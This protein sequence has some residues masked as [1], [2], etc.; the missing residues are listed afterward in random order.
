MVALKIDDIKQFTTML[1]MKE[2]FDWFLVKEVDIV[3]FNAF[4]IDG[5]IKQGYYTAE[6]LEE[7]KIEGY[8][9]WKVLRPVCFSLI[10]G[11]KLPK[12]FQIVFLMSR[13][14]V[15]KFLDSRRIQMDPGQIGGLYLH[16]RYEEGELTCITGSSLNFFT[17]D[18]SLESEWD[19]GAKAF[20]KKQM[21]VFSQG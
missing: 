18:K 8:S 9:S 11:H 19:E 12:S 15:K 14:Y 17:L 10:K 13:D 1:F 3:T 4:S 5:H 21:I 6:E 20:L 16:I 7:Q 2:T